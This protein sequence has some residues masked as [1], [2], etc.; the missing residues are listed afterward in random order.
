MKHRIAIVFLLL[1]LSAQSF[2]QG[3]FSIPV[4]NWTYDVI[5]QLQTRGYFLQ[6]SPAIKPYRRLEV[7]EA[8][9]K[10]EKST[11]IS[12]LPQAD[13]WLIK[14][15]DK[16]FSYETNRLKVDE[17]DPDTSFTGMRL[18][19]EAFFNLAKG[20]YKTFKYAD[21]VEFR[22]T[23]RSEI[24]LDVGD[25]L[26]LYTDGTIDQ[27][28]RDDTIYTHK[29]EFGPLAP[30]EQAYGSSKFGLDVLTQQAYV[31]YSDHYL[32]LTFGRD[33][34]SWGYGNN[35]TLL[36]SPTAG[37]FDMISALVKTRVVKF[38]WFVAQLNQMPEFTPDSNNSLESGGPS[39]WDSIPP[40]AN[41][42]FTGSRIEFNIA[43]KVFLGAYQAAVFGGPNASINF[44]NTNPL[45]VNYETTANDQVE[46]ST[47]NF[48]GADIG[49]FWPKNLNF[50]SDLMIDDWQV[51][52]K[53]LA[54]LK[55][56]LYS[57]DVGVKASNMLNGIGMSG[58]DANLQ[59]TMVRNRVYNEYNWVSY[60]KLMLKNYPIASPYGDDFWNI[61]LRLS[62][63]LTYDWKFGIELMHL[64]HGG[65]NIYGPYTMP[66]LT[67]P[68]I[69]VQSGYAEPFPFG[70]IQET[71]LYEASVMYQP[72]Q[73]F[74]GQAEISYSQNRNSQYSPGVDKGVFSL[75]FTIYYNFA[76]TVPF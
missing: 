24:G 1:S 39:T 10:F 49:V 11:D 67:D 14:K 38:N 59:Y 4:D 70:V 40:L 56:N 63:W 29:S 75:L 45:R 23:L 51:D 7:A 30:L 48:V 15:L 73:D 17:A 44:L 52:H 19:E 54:D 55:P 50:Y 9:Q 16:E 69:T 28:L 57:V 20:D 46:G 65:W 74:Y 61:D 35:G 26:V 25:H 37:A 31:Q 58:T 60:Q 62:Q 43:D 21:K 5:Q 6:L 13:Q 33:Y 71:N 22:P 32:D 72:Q 12:S 3:N 41:R 34:L 18:S 64:E 76:A 53:T 47:N 27:T 68:S 36:V 42:Y 2:A 8:L 66:W